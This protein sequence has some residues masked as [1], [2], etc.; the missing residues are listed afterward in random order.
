MTAY[1]NMVGDMPSRGKDLL[2]QLYAG[3]QA[4]DR[5]CTLLLS[6]AALVLVTPYERLKKPAP[7]STNP[8]H[9]S[10]DRFNFHEAASSIDRLAQTRLSDSSLWPQRAYESWMRCTVADASKSFDQ[11]PELTSMTP[12]KKEDLCGPVVTT[13]RHALAHGNIW[14]TGEPEIECLYFCSQSS[15]SPVKWRVFGVAPSDFRV[16]LL[17]WCDWLNGQSLL[18]TSTLVFAP[19]A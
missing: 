11:W 17:R 5:E 2:E 14:T 12:L 16:F 1:R 3:A 4:R 8:P 15:V 10:A 18:A 9:P 6:V 7:D 19:S 13:L